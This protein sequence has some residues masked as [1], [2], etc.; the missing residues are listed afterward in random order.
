MLEKLFEPKTDKQSYSANTDSTPK[1]VIIDDRSNKDKRKEE[2]KKRAKSTIP[3]KYE[4]AYQACKDNADLLKNYQLLNPNV[5]D[6]YLSE[7]QRSYDLL[8]GNLKAKVLNY[9]NKALSKNVK[10]VSKDGS[11]LI[12][13]IKGYRISAREGRISKE[14][15]VE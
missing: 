7:F 14:Y 15:I 10:I 3:K 4:R 9:A 2:S 12:G 5:I 8:S 1:P 6:Q 13:E 11:L